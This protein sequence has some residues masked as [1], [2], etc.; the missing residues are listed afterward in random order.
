MSMMSPE[1]QLSSPFFLGGSQIIVS[2]PTNTMDTRPDLQSMRGNN[3]P[4]SHA[5]AFH[6]LIP[7]HNL[8]GY[9]GSRFA[10]YRARSAGARRSSARAGRSTGS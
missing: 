2:Y 5:V 9:M 8:V 4:F 6:E 3:I 10:S 7:G 1:A